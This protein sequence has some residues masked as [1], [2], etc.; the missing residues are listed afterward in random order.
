MHAFFFGYRGTI[1]GVGAG[2]MAPT[3][4]VFLLLA[5][6]LV[7]GQA[8]GHDFVSYDDPRYVWENP[9]VAGGLTREGLA[10]V[11]THSHG[12]NWHPLTGLSHMLD[13][14]CFGLCAEG[15]HAVN[16]LLHA[17]TV[18]LLFLVLRQMTRRSERADRFWPSA[19]VAAVFAVHPLRVES[20]AWV[21]ERK[22][23]LSGLLF[24]LTLAAYLGYARHPFSLARYLL[25]AL[26]F[27]LGLMAKPMLVTVP[28]VLLLLDYWP[29]GRWQGSGEK[30]RK[31]EREEGRRRESEFSLSP[32]LPFSPDHGYTVPALLTTRALLLEKLPLLALAAAAS[33]ATVLAQSEAMKLNTCVSLPWRIGNALV[34]YVAYLGQLFC[35]LGLAVFYPHPENHLPVWEVIAAFLVLAGI[36]VGALCSWRR[37]YLLVGWLW[38]LGMMVPTIGLVQ[39]GFQSMADRYTYLPQ[40]GLSVALA[41][42]VAEVARSWSYRRWVCGLGSALVLAGLMA[43]AWLQTSYWRNSETLWTHAVACTA[44]NA[45]A[46]SYLGMALADLGRSDE[47][48]AH[49]RKALEIKPDEAE[50]S[51]HLGYVLQQSPPSRPVRP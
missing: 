13:C 14:Q 35:P 36:T 30:G 3:V 46:H 47:A 26:V 1:G 32:L 20:V 49:F 25:V 31:G 12:F 10:W 50:A 39:V 9:H 16:V 24:M 48:I 5:V 18:V 41:W 4:R 44:Q 33:V 11:F 38:Y 43:C 7:F 2:S 28:F 8:I 22:D 34:S 21:A 45:K 23:V 19:F 15:H 17:G 37:P 42:G 51:L 40:V 27:A 29:L 6:T